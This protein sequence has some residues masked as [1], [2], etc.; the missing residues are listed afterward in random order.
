MATPHACAGLVDVLP[1]LLRARRAIVG[2]TPAPSTATLAAVHESGTP[3]VSEVAETLGLDLSTVS[4]QVTHLRQRGLLTA[5]PDPQDGRSQRLSL[6][7]TGVAELRSHR[8]HLVDTLVARLADWDDA[9]I[10]LLAR[11]LDRLARAGAPAG[12]DAPCAEPD[13]C[14]PRATA[15]VTPTPPGPHPEHHLQRNA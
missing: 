15:P 5:V 13:A 14:G 9:E 3:R 4:R 6:T 7:E 1:G 10:D 11:L 2:S 8:R 12:T